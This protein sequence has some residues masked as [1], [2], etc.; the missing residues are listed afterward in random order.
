LISQRSET[1]QWKRK[2]SKR[3][4]YLK[5][6]RDTL[7]IIEQKKGNILEFVSI[8]DNLLKRTPMAQVQRS[9]ISKWD[10][11]KWNSFCESK[12]IF[13]RQMTVYRWGKVLH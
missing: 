7:N 3:I 13:I 2:K 11:I 8:G 12:N 1:I 10:L 9:S 6:K 4:K 5:L